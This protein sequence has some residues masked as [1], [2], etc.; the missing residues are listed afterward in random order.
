MNSSTGVP[1]V[2]TT[3][4]ASRMTSDDVVTR[5]RPVA[6]TRARTWSAPRSRKGIRPAATGATR[7][8]SMSSKVTWTPD[9]GQGDAQGQADVPAPAD[10]A[11]RVFHPKKS[12]S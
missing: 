7:A 4:S 8:S 9:L 11:H 6:R 12:L 1:I 2:T 3:V 5:R 10:D